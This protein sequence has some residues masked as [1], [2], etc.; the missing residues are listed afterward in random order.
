MMPKHAMKE[1]WMTDCRQSEDPMSHLHLPQINAL[2][3]KGGWN[4]SSYTMK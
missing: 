4:E 2:L 1:S 3:Q